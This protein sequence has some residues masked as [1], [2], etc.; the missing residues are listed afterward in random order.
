MPNN[1]LTYFASS[2][3]ALFI[4]FDTFKHILFMDE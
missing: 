4:T 1:Y 3:I 2:L